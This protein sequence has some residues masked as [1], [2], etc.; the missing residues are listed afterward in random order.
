MSLRLAIVIMSACGVISDAILIAFYPQFFAM[1]YGVTSTVHVG[2]YIATISIAVMVTL[3]L[4]ARV[5]RHVETMH[6]VFVTQGLAGL[7]GMASVMTE[8]VAAFWAVTMLMFMTKS[9]YLLMFPYL[10]RV[11]RAE[12][13]SA[14]VGLLAVVVHLAGIFGAM[15]GGLLLQRFGADACLF[16]MAAGDFAQMAL[17]LHVI[18]AGKVVGVLGSTAS[19]SRHRHGTLPRVLRLSVLMLLF[20]FSAYLIRPF[21]S[22]Y[23]E[24]TTGIADRTLTGLVFAIPGL[25]A[26]LALWLDRQKRTGL[27]GTLINLILGGVGL[28]LQAA[29]WATA[30]LIG[31]CLYGWALFRVS[32]KLEVTLFRISTPQAYA[33][34]FSIANGFQNLGVL[35]S[36]F[37]AGYVVEQLGMTS[38]FLLAAAGLLLTA[39][40]SHLIFP[41]RRRLSPAPS[42]QTE[43]AN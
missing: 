14:T 21:F 43:H 11:E 12:T 9:S 18:R 29:P 25:M 41:T 36:S 35:L 8:T 2:A 28:V 38:P 40:A 24:T 30:I 23:W 31:R 22:V 26:L 6:L 1:R 17:C 3:P 34:D 13:H 16:A 37:C 7:L 4:W 42:C 15:A 33:R 19:S 5:A 10:M 32:V 27:S 39:V 20:D